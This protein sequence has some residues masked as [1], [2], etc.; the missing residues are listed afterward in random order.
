LAVVFGDGRAMD[1][2]KTLAADA[3][4]PSD[5]RRDALDVLIRSGE[6][7]LA[8]LLHGL[9]TDRATAAVAARGLS[10]LGNDQTPSILLGNFWKAPREARAAIVSALTVREA[11]ALAL[12]DQVAK[13]EV[14][15]EMVTAADGPTSNGCG[16]N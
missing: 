14:P 15:K 4:A 9:L 11:W 8:P 6:K 1:D 10:A 7:D 16:T 2:L 3:K 12:L 5:A 13:E